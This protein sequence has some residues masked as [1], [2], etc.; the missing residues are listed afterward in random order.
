M[1]TKRKGN[2][3]FEGSP[4]DIS[5]S[6]ARKGLLALLLIFLGIGIVKDIYGPGNYSINDRTA[7]DFYQ[8]WGVGIGPRVSGGVLKSPHAN[9]KI[10]ADF[11]DA[12]IKNSNDQR[13]LGTNQAEHTYFKQGLDLTGTPLQYAIFT[14]LPT[15]YSLAYLLFLGLQLACFIGTILLLFPSDRKNW[16]SLSFLTVGLMVFYGPFVNVLRDGNMGPMQ[17]FIIAA[18]V[19]FSNRAQTRKE[20]TMLQGAFLMSALVFLTLLKP[21]VLI[22][23]SGLALSLLS[24]YGA[25]VFL[26]SL[27]AGAVTGAVLI[28]ATSLYFGSW[29]VWRDWYNYFPAI[30]DRFPYVVW[31]GNCSASRLLGDL[32]GLP[33]RG[34]IVAMGVFLALWG[35]GVLVR[36]KQKGETLCAYLW[37]RM[38]MLFQDPYLVASGAV[39]ATLA[40]AP[41]VWLHYYLLSLLPAFYLIKTSSPQNHYLVFVLVSLLLSSGIVPLILRHDDWATLMAATAWI[42]LWYGL[43]LVVKTKIKEA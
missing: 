32:S 8:Y 3:L 38:A 40:I 4:D 19:V 7:I 23:T 6:W 10:Y 5:S 29:S 41:L 14:F 17:L 34:S 35:L 1:K 16:L 27:A 22:I 42:P 12:Y 26:A 25:Y 11:F 21:N 36:A 28:S 13:L 24:L 20:K 30:D 18:L 39:V 43:L 2:K 15:N 31:A 9:Q 37:T 33:L